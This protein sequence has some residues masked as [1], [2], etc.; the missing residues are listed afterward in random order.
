MGILALRDLWVLLVRKD[1]KDLRD[2]RTA[3]THSSL[4]AHTAGER[5]AYLESHGWMMAKLWYSTEL[6]ETKEHYIHHT[7]RTQGHRT[8]IAQL[9]G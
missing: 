1:L 4:L 8:V 7:L 3:E 5:V 6:A 2:R 9:L